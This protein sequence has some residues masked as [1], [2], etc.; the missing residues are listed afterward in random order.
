MRCGLRGSRV[1]F[2]FG[3][4]IAG[5]HAP[6]DV[7]CVKERRVPDSN[8]YHGRGPRDLTPGPMRLIGSTLQ[9][10]WDAA[11]MRRPTFLP[12]VV[13][14]GSGTRRSNTGKEPS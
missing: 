3:L 12:L 11:G 14:A 7:H 4:V 13:P 10:G 9:C 1:L 5:P 2:F 6:R 8:R